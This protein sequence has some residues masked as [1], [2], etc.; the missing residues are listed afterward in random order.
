MGRVDERDAP[1]I[2]QQPAHLAGEPIMGVDEVIFLALPFGKLHHAAGEGGQ[3]GR[4]ILFIQALVRPGDDINDAQVGFN[5]ND[6]ALARPRGAGVDV[7]LDSPASQ[8][9]RTIEDVDVHSA[10][11]P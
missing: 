8:L 11:I 3:L 5:L 7:H 10:R 4:Q 9:A 2:P 1:E 6:F